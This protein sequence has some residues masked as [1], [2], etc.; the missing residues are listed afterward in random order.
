MRHLKP[1]RIEMRSTARESVSR[2]G[3]VKKKEAPT[4]HDGSSKVKQWGTVAG[5]CQGQVGGPPPAEWILSVW[6]ST[7]GYG[8]ALLCSALWQAALLLGFPG[9]V[10][11]MQWEAFSW[12]LGASV[13]IWKT[14]QHHTDLILQES[15]P[16]YLRFPCMT[17]LLHYVYLC[18][19]HLPMTIHKCKTSV[20][21]SSL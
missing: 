9:N 15:F 19:I 8:W 5:R 16:N 12:E 7:M 1:W 21:S 17:E 3:R 11:L 20:F 10:M 2:A 13:S 4:S 6:G 18:I 14:L